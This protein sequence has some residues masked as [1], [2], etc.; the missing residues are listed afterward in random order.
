VE[1]LIGTLD[2]EER[3]RRKDNVKGVETSTTNV[4]QK[5]NFRKFNKKKNQK[6]QENTNKPVQTAQFKKKSNNNNK[7]KGGCF[8]CGNDQH[9]LENALIASS[10]R[11]RNPLML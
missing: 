4:V 7:R 8:V 2:V 10:H 9:G 1:E 11:T 3:A 5:R 6:K